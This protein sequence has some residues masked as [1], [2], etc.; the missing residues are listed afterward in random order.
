[1]TDWHSVSSAP[2]DCDLELSVIERGEAHALVFSMSAYVER[3]DE[4]LK[5]LGSF[6]RPDALA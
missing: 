5:R 1:M 3:M 2:L 6:C 4:C